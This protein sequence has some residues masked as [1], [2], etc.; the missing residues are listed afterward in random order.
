[1]R[2]KWGIT[3]ESYG[4]LSPNEA[5][6]IVTLIGNSF[7]F[8][9]AVLAPYHQFSGFLSISR[10]KLGNEP[11]VDF[12]HAF[13][14]HTSS[15]LYHLELYKYAANAP[16]PWTFNCVWFVLQL[17]FYWNSQTLNFNWSIFTNVATLTNVLQSSWMQ[18]VLLLGLFVVLTNL[19][20]WWSITLWRST[21]MRR[22]KLGWW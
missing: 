18:T 4:V 12:P 3:Y 13:T 10:L 19:W 22:T 8:I 2:A 6:V 15:L 5:F 11:N 7:L 20:T 9:S 1:M 14:L 21:A 16:L 17:D